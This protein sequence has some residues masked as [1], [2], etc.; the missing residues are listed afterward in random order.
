[1]KKLKQ[2]PA[3]Q[4]DLPFVRIWRLDQTLLQHLHLCKYG[5][6]AEAFKKT[7]KGT[8]FKTCSSFV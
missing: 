8:H 2:A 5:D 6:C 4:H 1:M 7:L 3:S